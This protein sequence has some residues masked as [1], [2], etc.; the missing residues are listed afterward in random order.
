LPLPL[1]ELLPPLREFAGLLLQRVGLTRQVDIAAFDVRD[2][3][4]QLFG[5]LPE[6][7][8]QRPLNLLDPVTLRLQ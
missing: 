4:L 3:L 2:V 7:F 5:H 1:I 6:L 8:G